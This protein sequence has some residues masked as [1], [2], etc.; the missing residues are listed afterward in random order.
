MGNEGRLFGRSIKGHKLYPI[1]GSG[2][3]PCVPLALQPFVDA[4]GRMP[5]LLRHGLV[6]FQSLDDPVPI[7]SDLGLRAG[8][9]ETVT[10]RGTVSQDL[11]QRR[12]VHARLA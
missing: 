12:P 7:G 2:A 3:F 4:F 8:S 9:L 11:L 6:C 1:S 5:L 10:G